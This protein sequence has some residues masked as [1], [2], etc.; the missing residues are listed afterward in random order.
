[1]ELLIGLAL[2]PTLSSNSLVNCRTIVRHLDEGYRVVRRQFLDQ[3]P[4][5]VTELLAQ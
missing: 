5:L 3:V 2:F 4:T 1:M